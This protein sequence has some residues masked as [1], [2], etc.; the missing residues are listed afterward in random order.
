MMKPVMEYVDYRRYIRDFYRERKADSAVP[1]SWGVFA[2]KA[3]IASPVFLQYVCEGKK[4]LGEKSS[5]Q[6]AA[7]MGLVGYEET[8]FCLLVAYASAK[9]DAEKK[10]VL[11]QIGDLARTHKVRI[12]GAKEYDF[13]KSWKN[14]LLRELASAMPKATAKQL[15]KASRNRI[16]T[17]EVHEILDFLVQAGFLVQG[18][19]GGYRECNRSLRMDPHV[20]KAVSS[21]LQRQYAELAVDALKNEPPEKR[22]MTGLTVGITRES[23]DRVVAE[24]AECRRRIN[25]IATMTPR[26]DEVYRLNMQFFPLTDM[27]FKQNRPSAKRRK[28]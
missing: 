14:S 1:F 2:K 4:N 25:A 27:N 12:V 23:Y 10:A 17:S 28:K 20:A 11:E 22:N 19:D 13:F 16:P 8:Y 18:A 6:V 5:P 21:D 9:N 3:G 24:L 15:S 7:A 26:T